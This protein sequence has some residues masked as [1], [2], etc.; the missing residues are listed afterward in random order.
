MK[1]V[2]IKP[3]GFSVMYYTKPFLY[4][5]LSI[6]NLITVNESTKTVHRRKRTLTLSHLSK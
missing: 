2:K 1:F 5:Y 3:K 4:I 6:S